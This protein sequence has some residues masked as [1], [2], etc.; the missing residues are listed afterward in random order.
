[1]VAVT[2]KP[3]G[4]VSTWSPWLIQIVS[5]GP[6][7]RK[8]RPPETVT[9]ARPYSRPGALDDLAS[10]TLGEPH[11]PVAEAEDGNLQFEETGVPLGA[12]LS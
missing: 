9:C 1:M 12:P 2:E 11:H 5:T 8:S 4:A 7:P 6:R 10:V 3:A